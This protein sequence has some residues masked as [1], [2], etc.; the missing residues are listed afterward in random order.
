MGRV[1][2]L[3]PRAKMTDS[4]TESSWSLSA[5]SNAP[6]DFIK[7]HPIMPAELCQHVGADGTF[8]W[9]VAGEELYASAKFCLA[10]A[11]VHGRKQCGRVVSALTF[12]VGRYD[13]ICRS[14]IECTRIPGVPSSLRDDRGSPVRFGVG[15]SVCGS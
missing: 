13:F 4:T 8:H 10:A 1:L 2:A 14:S 12:H 15:V 5:E 9:V 3:C 6:T 11:I 7:K